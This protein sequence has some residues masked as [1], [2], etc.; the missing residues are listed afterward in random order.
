METPVRSGS[1]AGL[2][3]RQ[4]EGGARQGRRPS[5]Q[6]GLRTRGP[7]RGGG[8]ALTLLPSPGQRGRRSSQARAGGLPG[9]PTGH[10]PGKPLQGERRRET[11]PGESSP[12][13]AE[14]A[15]GYMS[16]CAAE[17]AAAAA[18]PGEGTGEGASPSPGY[19]VG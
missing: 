11:N 14:G 12:G 4:R 7:A 16:P 2:R 6:R 19:A 8:G 18:A 13:P 9:L 15:P 1:C 17:E 5:P 10:G 3:A